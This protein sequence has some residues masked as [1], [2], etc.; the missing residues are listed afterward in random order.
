M[1]YYGNGISNITT[2]KASVG[3]VAIAGLAVG[4]AAAGVVNALESSVP[5]ACYG[6]PWPPRRDADVPQFSDSSVF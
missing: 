4:L 2:T 1:A 6:T 5:P 3:T